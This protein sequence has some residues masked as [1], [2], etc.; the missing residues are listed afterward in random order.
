MPS[1]V[2]VKTPSCVSTQSFCPPGG[3]AACLQWDGGAGAPGARDL[4]LL[5]LALLPL[6]KGTHHPPPVTRLTA[7]EFDR[8]WPSRC[9]GGE[10]PKEGSYVVCT[11][12]LRARGGAPGAWQGVRADFLSWAIRSRAPHTSLEARASASAARSPSVPPS[13]GSGSGHVAVRQGRGG[14][15]GAPLHPDPGRA[16]TPQSTPCP[17]M[18]PGWSDSLAEV[19]KC[20]GDP[21]SFPKLVP[22]RPLLGRD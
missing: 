9:S 5:R 14:V 6:P 16:L 18:S 2:E 22:G 17:Q 11:T 1:Q 10:R 4:P 3:R 12:L 8:S 15:S 13:Q 20:Q 7:L 19:P 21:S